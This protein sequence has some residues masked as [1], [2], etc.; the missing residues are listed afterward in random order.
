MNM[1]KALSD[2]HIS[3]RKLSVITGLPYATVYGIVN[4]KINLEECQ[5]KTL[6]PIAAYFELSVD[7]LVYHY[8]DFQTFRNN[9]HH[10]LVKEDELEV[11]ADLLENKTI[12]YF[13]S[14]EDYLKAL[15]LLALV[16]YVLKKNNYPVC[17]EYAFLRRQKLKKPYYVGGRSAEKEL[18]CIPEFV[19]HN[20]YEGDLY[21]AV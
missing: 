6:K 10:R 19:M 8:E 7:D 5:Y 20:I 16:D 15:Y 21:D 9:L 14:H 18:K 1:K 11:I 2:K 4:G 13:C 17:R 3:I 12:D